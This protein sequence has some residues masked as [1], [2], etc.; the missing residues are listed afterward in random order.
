[1]RTGIILA[2][3]QSSRFG[4]DKAFA[5]WQGRT[6]L[7]RVADAL[8]PHVDEL[9]VLAR[10]DVPEDRCQREAPGAIVLADRRPAGPIA[11]LHDAIPLVRGEQVVI[12]A[13]D[14]PGLRPD[15]IARLLEHE[16]AILVDAHG[17]PLAVMALPSA[18]LRMRLAAARG[19]MDLAQAATPVRSLSVA[20]DQDFPL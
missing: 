20:L 16:E 3:G 1:M 6:F 13:C 10:A 11:A 7:A 8:R 9:L 4:S 2:G 5:L 17:D 19:L 18:A 12:A 14:A 15:D